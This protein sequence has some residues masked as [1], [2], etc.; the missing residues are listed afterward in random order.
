MARR[1][2]AELPNRPEVLHLAREN[3]LRWKQQN[4]GSPGLLRCY[5]EW[6]AI[7]ERPIPEIISVLVAET[8][9]GQRLRQNSP[10]A[11]AIPPRQ[12]WEIKKHFRR[13]AT[14]QLEMV[15]DPMLACTLLNAD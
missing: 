4:Q 3:L 6:E 5:T 1:V 15:Q 8:D 2:A 12:V 10:F 9:E 13:H 11:G 7:L 14:A